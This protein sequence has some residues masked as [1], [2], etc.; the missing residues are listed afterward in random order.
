MPDPATLKATEILDHLSSQD[1][2]VGKYPNDHAV[3]WIAEELRQIM[4]EYYDKGVESK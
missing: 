1:W 4:I 3:A 2:C